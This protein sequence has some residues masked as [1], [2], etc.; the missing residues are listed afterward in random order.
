MII[1]NIDLSDKT[2][3]E[4]LLFLEVKINKEEY[5]LWKKQRKM[6]KDLRRLTRAEL[7]LDNIHYAMEKVTNLDRDTLSMKSR[8]REH[9]WARALFYFYAKKYTSGMSLET[10]GNYYNYDHA[11]VIHN[12]KTVEN[13][14]ETD[15]IF[16]KFKLETDRSINNMLFA[17]DEPTKV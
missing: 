3:K 6:I 12:C 1:T 4:H 13:L 9:V 8:V 11:A 7:K 17:L 16:R 5:M 10:I 14:C 2:E 15:I